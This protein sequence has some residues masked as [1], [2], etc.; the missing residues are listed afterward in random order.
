MKEHQCA[1]RKLFKVEK[2]I[3]IICLNIL[4]IIT[5]TTFSLGVLFIEKTLLE[6]SNYILPTQKTAIV[7]IPEYGNYKIGEISLLP[8]QVSNLSTPIN[9][10]QADIGYDPLLVEIQDILVGD[11]FANIFIQKDVRNDLGFARITG[12]IPNP[13]FT[14][15]SGI[16]A[17]VL[18]RC[19]TSGAGHIS[20]LPTTQV[21]ANDGRATNV[22][23]T[24]NEHVYYV[25]EDELTLPELQLQQQYLDTQVLGATSDK[26][27]FYQE[28]ITEGFEF[29]E[30]DEIENTL[31]FIDIAYTYITFV[32][33]PIRELFSQ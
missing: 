9:V 13:G 31:T 26:F 11:S 18:F 5:I 20:I 21:L 8:I 28:R 24:F 22:L 27:E 1:T 30:T 6:N 25:A 4:V 29:P 17:N 33:N 23:A 7:G 3:Q 16:F 2:P 12:G 15:E 10:I 32:T 14:E 19:K